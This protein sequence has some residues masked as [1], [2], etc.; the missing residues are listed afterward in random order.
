MF[1]QEDDVMPA[2][3][4]AEGLFGRNGCIDEKAGHKS[5]AVATDAFGKIWYGD[6]TTFDG[7]QTLANVL[8]VRC[9]II[10]ADGY[11]EFPRYVAEPLTA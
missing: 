10:S 3:L 7:V 5:V 4:S 2:F 1:Y 11:D 9:M 6:L 8:R